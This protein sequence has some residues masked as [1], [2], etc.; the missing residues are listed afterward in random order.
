MREPVDRIH[1]CPR[2][3][4]RFAFHTEVEDHLHV[5]HPA[6]VDDDL[7]SAPPTPEPKADQASTA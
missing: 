3:E 1:Q 4:L 5:D 7:R 6:P 2:C